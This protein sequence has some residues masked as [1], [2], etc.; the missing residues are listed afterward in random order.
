MR[1]F[2][3][4]IVPES[5]DCVSCLFEPGCARSV[6]HS[7]VCVLAT[8]KFND[9]AVFQAYKIDDVGW[10]KVL[11]AEFGSAQ[12]AV[13]QGLPKALFGVGGVGS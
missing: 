12:L 7:S 11:A 13:A 4:F 8:V 2:E 6:I 9:Q 5:H 10:D 3:K 1:V